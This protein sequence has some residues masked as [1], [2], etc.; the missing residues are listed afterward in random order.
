MSKRVVVGELLDLVSDFCSDV[1]QIHSCL[2]KRH[3]KGLHRSHSLDC[4]SDS[5]DFE[6]AF[7]K[8]RLF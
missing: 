7:Q 1:R 8:T 5:S 4:A 2:R 3:E 6:R